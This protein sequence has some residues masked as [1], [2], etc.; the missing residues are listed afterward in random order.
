MLK[1]N[2]H[3]FTTVDDAGEEQFQE[4]SASKKQKLSLNDYKPIDKNFVEAILNLDFNEET[5]FG[6][7]D[8]HH[9]FF[10]QKFC[11]KI[12]NPQN[13]TLMYYNPINVLKCMSCLLTITYYNI[14]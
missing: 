14:Q 11:V 3:K 9:Y 1:E 6:N 7:Y 8:F 13:F 10:D 5:S 2:I 12:I 4:E